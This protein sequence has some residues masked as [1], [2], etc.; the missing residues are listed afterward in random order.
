MASDDQKMH[1][2]GTAGNRTHVTLTIP[3]KLENQWHRKW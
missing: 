2:R 3:Q 1:K